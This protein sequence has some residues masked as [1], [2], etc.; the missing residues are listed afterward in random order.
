MTSLPHRLRKW[1][2]KAGLFP[3]LLAGGLLAL[4]AAAPAAGAPADAVRRGGSAGAAELTWVG[5]PGESVEVE[6]SD[7][8]NGWSAYHSFTNAGGVSALPPPIGPAS[9]FRARWK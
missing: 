3:R 8:L 5:H 9:F 2:S 7:D 1:S 6:A 4:G